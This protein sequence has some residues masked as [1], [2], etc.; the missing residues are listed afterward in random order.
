[1]NWP[2]IPPTIWLETEEEARAVALSLIRRKIKK[3]AFDTETTGLKVFEDYPVI[4]SISD[5]INRYAGWAEFLLIPE[6]RQL[7][8]DEDLI[9][10]GSNLKF[11][12]HMCANRGIDIKCKIHDTLVMD[13]LKDENRQGR[14]GLKEIARDYCNIP[15]REFKDVF[16]MI[17]KRKGFPDDTPGEAISRKMSDPEGKREAIQYAGLDAYAVY[18]VYEYLEHELMEIIIGDGYNL[19]DY[20][21]RI[22]APFTKVLWNMERRGFTICAGYFEGI[23]IP[24]QKAILEIEAEF[25]RKVMDLGPMFAQG[26]NLNSSLQLREFFYNTLGKQ[27]FKWTTGGASGVKNPSTDKEVLQTWADEGDAFAQMLINHSK[28]TTIFDTFV[29]G[30]LSH[31]DRNY[32]LHTSLNQATAVT[33][34]LS[35]SGPNCQNIP[36]PATD[37]FKIRDGFIASPGKRLLVFDYSQ[38][39]MMIMAHKSGDQIMIEAI[40]TGK[41][42][43]CLA[44]S[45]IFHYPYEEVIQAKK[46]EKNGVALTD[47]Q[48]Q[49]LLL[50]QAM[51]NVGYGIIYGIG[52]RKLAHDLTIE[53]QKT[54][55]NR[56]VTEAEAQGYIDSWYGLFKDVKRFVDEQKAYVKKFGFV[57]T[58]L[59]RFRRLPEI[60]SSNFSDKLKAERQA[61]NI[62]QGDAADILRVAMLVLEYHPRLKELGC[63]MILQVH[64]ELVFEIDDD[65]AKVKEASII[66]KYEMEMSFTEKVFKLLVNLGVE[67]GNGWSWR[68]A[69]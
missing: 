48:K 7:F 56:I 20:F 52:A 17:R 45:L 4:F 34:R 54:D 28:L 13:F 69:K 27:P 47:L 8:D 32:K 3:L 66:I 53:F 19:F 11:D 36:R 33:G 50:R 29:V 67:G 26:I 24:M 37:K 12:L 14:H 64:D 18:M 51:K 10:I 2:K 21:T 59:G 23:K 1:M 62:I 60:N 6:F 31:L 63:V 42:L 5:G 58:F 15:M 35:S 44:V 39:E 9:L 38:L 41:D 43:H 65:E 16:P 61:V 46:D 40:N 25:N 57:R 49:F 22:E 30:L 55:K 68:S